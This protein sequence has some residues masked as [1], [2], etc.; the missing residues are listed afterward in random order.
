M[1]PVV[2]R[3]LVTLAAGASLLLCLATG[4]LWV[5]SYWRAD[6]LTWRRFSYDGVS[7]DNANTVHFQNW[8][9]HSVGFHS[10]CGGVRLSYGSGRG[11]VTHFHPARTGLRI[12]HDPPAG[13]PY[14]WPSGT[15]PA[16][17]RRWGGFQIH[18]ELIADSGNERGSNVVAPHWAVVVLM[19]VLSVAWAHRYRR[20]MGSKAEQ[21]CARC[22]Y[23]LRATPDRCPECGAV[24][25]LR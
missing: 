21:R 13:Y 22:G 25:V 23:D 9:S 20:S 14:T 8:S 17:V 18:S 5:R 10:A 3:C 12:W 15:R 16:F 11:R 24:P 19:L 7:R 4:G 2:K 1:R 6:T